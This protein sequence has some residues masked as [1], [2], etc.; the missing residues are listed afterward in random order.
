VSVGALDRYPGEHVGKYSIGRGTLDNH[1]YD[2]SFVEADITIML[3]S[4][5]VNAQ[6]RAKDNGESDTVFIYALEVALVCGDRVTGAPSR[7]ACV[8]VGSTRSA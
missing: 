3:K 2:I 1:K 8:D 4:I 5:M 7:A 6:E